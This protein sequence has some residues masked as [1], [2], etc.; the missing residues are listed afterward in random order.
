MAVIELGIV[1]PDGDPPE[2]EP[3]RRPLGR[4][5][6]R[7]L[8]VALVAV[9]CVLTVTGSARPDPRGLPQ[10]WA[11]PFG[12]ETDTFRLSGDSVYV[13]NQQTG[14]R[15]SAYDAR[16]GA[17][18]WSTAAVEDTTWINVIAG[19]M[20][21]M[22]S[23]VTTV[24][25]QE[26]DGSWSSREFNRT[27][28]AINTATG[29][30]AW[31][32]PGEITAMLG[33]RVLLSEWDEAGEQTRRLGL[34]R[35]RDGGPVWTRERGDVALWTTD[36][37]PGVQAERLVTLTE[38]GRAEVI[39]PA[40]GSVV[41]TGKLPWAGEPLNNNYSTFTVQGHRL[42]LDQTVQNRSTVTA[43]DTETLRR[44]W[45][46]EQKTSG[47][48]Y[49]CGPVV[50]VSDGTS[51]S[52]HDRDTGERLWHLPGVA[53]SYPLLGDRMVVEE[54]GGSRRRL[55]DARTGR[56]LADLG[57]AMPVWD[58][59]ARTTPYVIARTA[60]PLGLTSVSSFDPG[61]AEVVLRGAIP[62]VLDYSCQNEGDLLACVTEDNQL[63]VTDVG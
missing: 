25:H 45:S 47:G 46:V 61:S 34:V 51:M 40:D 59:S 14:R 60:E 63:A 57:V 48:S 52:G 21:L 3:G 49:G 33:D 23:G 24:T 2:P 15:L 4:P 7:R 39:S 62:R 22:P 28:T 42:Y 1:N 44:L 41:A 36:T 9:C 29:R 10:L 58:S 19:G 13:L 20:L 37:T 8:L 56:P 11:T 38:Q 17:V 55:I 53:S 32:R 31:T 35:L 18:R 30:P 6:L 12:P 43:Y 26:P 54:D 50:C 27:T 16:T 5:E